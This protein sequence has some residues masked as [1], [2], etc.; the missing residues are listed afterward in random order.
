MLESI[1]APLGL[2]LSTPPVEFNEGHPLWID[3]NHVR[4]G[5]AEVA[6][7]GWHTWSA[8]AG[9]AVGGSVGAL[10]GAAIGAVLGGWVANDTGLAPPANDR[11][12]ALACVVDD[13]AKRGA[14]IGGVAIGAIAARMAW[15]ASRCLEQSYHEVIVG[16]PCVTRKGGRPYTLVLGMH[17]DGRVAQIC[18]EVFRFGFKKQLACFMERSGGRLR[19]TREGVVLLKARL[20]SSSTS[21]R[22]SPDPLVVAAGIGHVRRLLSSPLLSHLEA[23]RFAVTKLERSY[24]APG[25]RAASIEGRLWVRRGLAPGLPA[26]V[27]DLRPMT[28]RSPWGAMWVGNVPERLAFRRHVTWDEL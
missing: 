10:Y 11:A 20:R 16:I 15:G 1:V 13:G 23:D 28:A 21:G 7:V 9:A 24:G 22:S 12:R 19:I 5:Q 17:V 2:E 27:H 8:A 18:D 3:V 14:L 25:A 26:G 6:G 4:S